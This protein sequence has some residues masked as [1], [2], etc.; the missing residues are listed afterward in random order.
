MTRFEDWEKHNLAKFAQEANERLAEQDTDLK[1]AINAYRHFIL[2]S[3]DMRSHAP[4]IRELLRQSP[5]G[6][7]AAELHEIIGLHVE[8]INRTLGSMPDVYKDRWTGPFRGQWAAV[9]CA[10]HVPADCPR[11][12]Q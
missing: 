8:T 12:D 2:E 4:R 6:F 3:T 11:P 10:A 1:T 9:W 7:T 5:D